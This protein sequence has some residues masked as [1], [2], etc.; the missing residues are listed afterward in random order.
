MVT[1]AMKSKDTCH[2]KK[3]YDKPREH[4][5]KERH[6]FGDKGPCSQT[7]GFSSSHVRMWELDHKEG[8][9]PKNC[10]FQIVFAEDS[11]NSIELQ[12]DQTSES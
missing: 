2:W 12:G 7:Y 8:W 3:S 1:A 11:K 6:H 10:C 9:A 4:I 5:K